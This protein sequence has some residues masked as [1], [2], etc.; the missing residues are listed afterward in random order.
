M[1]VRRHTRRH[2][3]IVGAGFAGLAT[4]LELDRIRRTD[5]YNITL[6]D[7]NAY[8]CYHALLYEVA[9][10]AATFSDADL[11]AIERGLTIRFKAF[12]NILAHRRINFLPAAVTGVD[13][14]N[15]SLTLAGQ[16]AVDYDALILAL[17]SV[18]NDF[19][20]PGLA[21]HSV[22]LK[23]LPD[24]LRIHQQLQ[25]L[26]VDC[27]REQRPVAIVI[28]GAGV[29]GVE[30]AGELRNY[31]LTRSRQRRLKPELVQVIILEAA[32]TVL[33]G[34]P[35]WVQTAAA[36][37]LTSLGVTIR[38]GQIIT[39]VDD[40]HLRLKDGSELPYNVFVWSGGIKAHPLMSQL[41][42]DCAGKRQVCVTSELLLPG[43]EQTF[44]IG[45]AVYYLD[46]ATNR[47]I[48][49]VAPLAVAQGR[50]AARNLVHTWRR[51]PLEPY[52]PERVGFVFP[53][54]GR[55]AISTMWGLPLTGWFGWLA[56]KIVDLQYFLSVLPWTQ[57][58]AVFWRGGR[59]YLKND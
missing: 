19:G 8:H 9:T 1:P 20:I 37:R 7:K 12:E 51:E 23:E 33:P 10:A 21:E 43:H 38:T 40:R 56:R 26:L 54:G 47:P 44:A 14:A 6:I 15:H 13:L 34:F 52:R 4:A 42:V 27:E 36:K 18:S 28:G 25:T 48:P 39:G 31:V 30:T 16:P 32:P 46:P 11:A 29:S 5:E 55:W 35:G 3:V 22:A 59:V 41:G 50:L 45:D 57:A 53:V 2:V 58:L 49:Q 17:G 24:A